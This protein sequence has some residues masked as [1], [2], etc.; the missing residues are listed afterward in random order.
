[1]PDESIFDDLGGRSTGDSDLINE[2]PAPKDILHVYQSGE[3]TVVGFGGVDVPGEVSVAAYRDQLYELIDQCDCKA[4][5]FDLTGVT[6]MP[7]GMLG[8]MASLNNRG[9]T[10][11][12]FNASVDVRDVLEVTGLDRLLHLRETRPG[13]N[14]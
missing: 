12:L 2:K 14:A 3:L 1:M 10:V 13:D 11:E 7:S 6:M 8:L 4:I 9:L 5:A